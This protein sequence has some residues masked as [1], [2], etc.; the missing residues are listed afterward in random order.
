ML[1]S[2]ANPKNYTA[3]QAKLLILPRIKQRLLLYPMRGAEIKIN[4][5]CLK[6]YKKNLKQVCLELLN[7]LVYATGTNELILVFNDKTADKLALLITYGNP[8][9]GIGSN[10]LR[11]ILK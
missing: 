6:T 9:I 4:N 11:D 2:L 7:K 1:F 3:A 8:E 10:I 5:Y